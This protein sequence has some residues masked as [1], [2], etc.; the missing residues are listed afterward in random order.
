MAETDWPPTPSQTAGLGESGLAVR[1]Q[2][3]GT[4]PDPVAA[5]NG[6]ATGNAPA[7]LCLR[8]GCEPR[9]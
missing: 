3:R 4:Q 8:N 9:G 2:L 6:S 7:E 1:L 5:T